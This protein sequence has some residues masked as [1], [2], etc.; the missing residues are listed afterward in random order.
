[1]L[2]MGHNFGSTHDLATNTACAPGGTQGN[3]IMYSRATSGKA[4]N[5]DEF[6][7]CSLNLIGLVIDYIVNGEK[8]CFKSERCL[9]LYQLSLF[10]LSQ[11]IVFFPVCSCE[12][13]VGSVRQRRGGGQRG[14]RL[15]RVR[16]QVLHHRVQAGRQAGRFG[17][18]H[19]RVQSEQ[20]TVLHR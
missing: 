15:Q 11:L 14:V 9:Y 3:Y 1:M 5:N 18:C 19:V 16:R 8:N 20:G 6:S 17:Q 12:S 2:E 13:D 10:F 4:A 7:S